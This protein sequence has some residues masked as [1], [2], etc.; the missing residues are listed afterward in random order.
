DAVPA[1]LD[2]HSAVSTPPRQGGVDCRDVDGLPGHRCY[3]RTEFVP[4]DV[5]RLEAR[6]R[7]P[8]G[9]GDVLIAIIGRRGRAGGRWGGPRIREGCQLRLDDPG[10]LDVV[11][12][13]AVVV[14]G[15]AP[16]GAVLVIRRSH[17][18]EL[19]GGGDPADPDPLTDELVQIELRLHPYANPAGVHDT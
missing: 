8:V 14:R 5:G 19:P 1:E 11:E 3:P 6:Q 18:V 17:V 2:L 13:P 4:F 16:S 7:P 15:I 12:P 10:D 9:I